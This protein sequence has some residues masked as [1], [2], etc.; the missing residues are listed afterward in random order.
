MACERMA[1]GSR[2]RATESDAQERVPP[3]GAREVSARELSEFLKSPVNAVLRYQLGIGVEGYRDRELDVDS[4]LGVPGGPPTW[5]LQGAMLG[6]EDALDRLYHQMQLSGQLPMGFIGAFAKER[7]FENAVQFAEQMRSFAAAF[8]VQEGVDLTARQR[9]PARGRS[10]DGTE[11]KVQYVAETPNW[12]EAEDGVSVLVTGWLLS[13]Y[14]KDLPDNARPIDR[15]LAPFM[16]FLMHLANKSDADADAPRSLRVGVIDIA[17]G[18]TAVWKWVVS[19]K[20]ARVYLERLTARYWTFLEAAERPSQYVDFT[21]KKLARAL[22]PDSGGDWDGI[23]ERLTAEDWNGGT[24]DGFNG[25]LV[26]EQAVD[27]Y[28]RDP[29]AEELKDLYEKFYSLPMSGVKES[30]ESGGAA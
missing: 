20:A 6:E 1:G 21:Y 8:G 22:E 9:V 5:E 16:A 11:T 7:F 13:Q 10:A 23:L 14:G 12:V 27:A 25:A 24:K 15:T 28:R 2:A 30:G 29:T 4:P 3:V 19:P 17:N 18:K 26:V